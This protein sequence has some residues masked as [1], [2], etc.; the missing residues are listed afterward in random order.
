MYPADGKHINL[1][2]LDTM[3]KRRLSG[4]SIADEGLA[5]GHRHWVRSSLD[6]GHLKW[7]GT[8]KTRAASKRLLKRRFERLVDVYALT[9]DVKLAKS[10][11]NRAEPAPEV[12]G[13]PQGR[14]RMYTT[15][16]RHCKKV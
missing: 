1:V 5:P 7:Q 3:I 14:N 6:I 2:E 9:M 8:C 15:R 11:L 10:A 12:I 13:A 4:L 16:V